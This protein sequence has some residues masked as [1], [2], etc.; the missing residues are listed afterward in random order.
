MV[1][2]FSF[3]RGSGVM[4]LFSHIDFRV[5][6]QKGVCEASQNCFGIS[7]AITSLCGACE[8]LVIKEVLPE[9][10]LIARDKNFFV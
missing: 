9:I 7:S 8:A 10:N 2:V 4:E 6:F 3:Q 5:S 1:R